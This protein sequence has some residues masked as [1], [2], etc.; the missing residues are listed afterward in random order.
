YKDNI[1][2]MWY[3]AQTTGVTFSSDKWTEAYYEAS[4]NKQGTSTIGYAYSEDG[5]NWKRLD[6]PVLKSEDTWELKSLM[7][8][9]VIWDGQERIFKMWYSGGEWFEPNSVGY[10][11][12]EDGVS[13]IKYKKNPIFFANANNS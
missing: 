4:K 9:S 3:S 8:P 12:S 11:T 13:W 2:H 7:N 6:T 10:A 5:V 1:Y